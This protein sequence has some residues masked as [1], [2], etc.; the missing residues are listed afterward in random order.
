LKVAQINENKEKK[1]N[2]NNSRNDAAQ[3]MGI[4]LQSPS[5]SSM[6]NE[7]SRHSSS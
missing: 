3:S 1:E 5:Y 6:W 2:R 4:W 7:A